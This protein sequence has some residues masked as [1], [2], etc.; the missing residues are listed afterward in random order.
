V[1]AFSP[2]VTF[3][4]LGYTSSS[5]SDVDEIAMVQG[6]VAV[7]TPSPVASLSQLISGG[8]TTTYTGNA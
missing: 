4:G 2:A 8:F 1:T 7:S 6:G 3:I 5:V